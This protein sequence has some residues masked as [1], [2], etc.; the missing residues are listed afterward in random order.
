MDR[1]LKRPIPVLLAALWAIRPAL[2]LYL[3]VLQLP[4]FS[5]SRTG[6]AILSVPFFAYPVYRI[7]SGY[8][9]SSRKRSVRVGL[10]S[11][12]IALLGV[13]ALSFIHKDLPFL[14]KTHSVLDG[15]LGPESGV[16][17]AV[18]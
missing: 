7:F 5:Y 3:L 8:V 16:R 13:Q 12:A 10:G 17:V 2:L 15:P 18:V 4:F 6:L 11:A 1:S 9:L 14:W